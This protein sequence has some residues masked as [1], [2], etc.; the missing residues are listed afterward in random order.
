MKDNKK[1]KKKTSKH[2]TKSYQH[3]VE[4][5]KIQKFI[6]LKQRCKKNKKIHQKIVREREREITFFVKENYE[7]NGR[8]ND[9][10]II[11][12]CE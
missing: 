10:F 1:K 7:Q 11:R 5:Q 3:K 4:F 2:K 9:K 8:E 6:N 12:G